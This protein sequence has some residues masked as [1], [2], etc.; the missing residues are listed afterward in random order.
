MAE[1]Y[2]AEAPT[3]E[4]AASPTRPGARLPL[5]QQK[6]E[7]R[8]R[9]PA[10]SQSFAALDLGTNNCRMLVARP[11]SGENG[12]GEFQVVDSFSRITRLGE[13]L[14]ANGRLSKGAMDRTVEA[15]KKCAEKMERRNVTA[16]RQVA[17]EACRRAA[18]CSE[19]LDRVR[20]ETGLEFDIITAHE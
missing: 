14:S 13:G 1:D 8:L 7:T 18:N 4:D 6:S 20:R 10:S 17:T 3:R 12:A 2:G 9:V 16:S 19:F 15:L 5:G 11:R